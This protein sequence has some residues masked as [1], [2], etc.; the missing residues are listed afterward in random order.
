MHARR[1]SDIL[2]AHPDIRA[3]SAS[4]EWRTK[5]MCAILVGLHVGVAVLVVPRLRS[6]W[7]I[8]VAAY[9]W[10]GTL[11]Q[12]LFLAMHELAHDLAF[13]APFANRALSLVVNLPLLVPAAIAFR[14]YHLDHHRHMGVPG[15]DVDLPSKLEERWVRGSASKLAWLSLQIVAYALRPLATRPPA[16]SAWLRANVVLQLVFDV[17]LVRTVG[18]LP[19]AY[20]AACV[21]LAG[22]L[23]P[24]AGHFLSE[25]YLVH[26]PTQE[27]VSYYGPLNRLTWNVGYHNEHHDFPRVPWSRLPAVRAAAPEHY[28]A[29]ATCPSWTGILV[30]FVRR[31]DVGLQ[32]HARRRE[33]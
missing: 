28:D 5:Y 16:P 15:K 33:R 27:T 7:T 2:R 13:R 6:W 22:G 8:A 11:A 12:A 30:D 1:P 29:L 9:A 3:L 14:D 17:V 10:G 18:G 20:L 4:P 25:H 31:P 19:V 32:S 21:L 24:C 23:H 26:H